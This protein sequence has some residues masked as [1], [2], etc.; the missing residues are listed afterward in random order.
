MLDLC[1]N[2]L[3]FT[4]VFGNLGVRPSVL[5]GFDLLYFIPRQ[6]ELDFF[7]PFDEDAK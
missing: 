3:G 1:S 4:I 5:R 6:P 7:L 2:F